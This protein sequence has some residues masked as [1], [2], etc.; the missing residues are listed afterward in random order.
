MPDPSEIDEHGQLIEPNIKSNSWTAKLETIP[1]A[2]LFEVHAINYIAPCLLVQRLHDLLKTTAST[3]DA[4]FIVQVQAMEGKFNT[5]KTG[6]HPHTNAAKAALNM[7]TRTSSRLFS[8]EGIFMNSVDT[9]WITD[10]YPINHQ[11]RPSPPLD[12]IDGASRVLDPII[13][14]YHEGG[15]P[16]FGVFFKDYAKS[17]W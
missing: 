9:G 3:T 5:F 10:E 12:E 14:F 2:E 15:P 11:H 7:I 4:T 17:D 16:K 6:Y 8:E 1:E 13:N